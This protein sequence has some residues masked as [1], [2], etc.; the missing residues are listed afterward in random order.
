MVCLSIAGA[1][2]AGVHY[3]AIDL[4]QQQ[5]VTAPSN[6]CRTVKISTVPDMIREGYDCLPVNKYGMLMCCK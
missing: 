1:F 2:V 5:S 3:L 6:E 4:P